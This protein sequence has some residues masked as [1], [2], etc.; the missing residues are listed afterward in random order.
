MARDSDDDIYLPFVPHPEAEDA[1]PLSGSTW[2]EM[3]PGFT[4]RLQQIDETERLAYIEKVSGFA[5]DPFAAP[6]DQ[7]PRF[8]SF[9]LQIEN[10]GAARLMFRSQQC[11]L[12]GWNAEILHPLA[13]EMMQTEYRMMGQE[14][15]PAYQRVG[16]ALIP[17]S[18][19]LRIGDSIAGL[20]IYPKVKPRT[21]QFHVEIQITTSAGDVV[22][23]NAPYRRLKKKEVLR[24]SSGKP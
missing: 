10:V 19:E 1:A 4:L 16:P 3:G 9:L 7:Q 14:M 18:R 2:V 13:M 22:T 12:K 20:L 6:E 11:L 8:E 5:I 15:Q 23:I 17:T 24:K 21:K